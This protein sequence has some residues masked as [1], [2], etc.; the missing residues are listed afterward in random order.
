MAKFNLLEIPEKTPAKP[1]E[2][3]FLGVDFLDLDVIEVT[4]ETTYFKGNGFWYVKTRKGE[5]ARLEYANEEERAAIRVEI[6]RHVNAFE[7][8]MGK[9]WKPRERL[10]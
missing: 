8:R 2:P 3:I 6:L 10:R 7:R 4:G 9:K 1:D 5:W